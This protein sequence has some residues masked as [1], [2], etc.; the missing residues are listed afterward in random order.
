MNQELRKRVREI[1]NEAE[2]AELSVCR[3]VLKATIE[4]SDIE[5]LARNYFRRF[6]GTDNIDKMSADQLSEATRYVTI[7]VQLL[8][9][10][11]LK[12]S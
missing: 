4:S 2:I 8:N 6:L 10:N 9:N 3:N 7:I 11:S 5:L 12:A 1:L